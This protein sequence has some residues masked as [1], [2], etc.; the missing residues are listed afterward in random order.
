MKSALAFIVF[1]CVAGVALAQETPRDPR[2]QVLPY[3]EG[4]VIS[5]DGHLGYQ[6]MIEFDPQERIENVSIGD[7][8]A[9]QI[10]PNRAATLLFVKPIVAHA[11]TNMTVV[12]TRRRYAFTLRA[13]EPVG[14]DDARIIYGLRFSYAG[15]QAAAEAVVA[16]SAFNFNYATTGSQTLTPLQ[17]FDDGRFTYFQMRE[18]GEVPAIFALDS[19]GE[20]ELVNSQMRGD[21][22]IVDRVADAFVLRYGRDAAIVRSGV[23]PPADARE[24]PPSTRRGRRS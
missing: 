7:S 16:P 2:L 11:V 23:A 19:H 3:E 20:E 1:L 18:G 9:W 6:M 22:T 8:L 14:P 12:T 24:R 21:I 10:T 17:V 4:Q 5:L 13:R 15:G